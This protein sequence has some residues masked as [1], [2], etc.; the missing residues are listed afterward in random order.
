MLKP[1]QISQQTPFAFNGSNLNVLQIN[2]EPWFVAKE[3]TSILEYRNTN[4]AT[5]LLDE[6]EKGTHLMR[7]LGGDQEV[8]IINESGLYSL[9]LRSKKP[10]AKEFKRWVTHEVLPA[11][12]KHGGYL[13]P[14]KTEELIANPD[15]IIQ[16]ATSLKSERQKVNFLTNEVAQRNDIIEHQEQELRLQTP[17]VK[18]YREV[19]NATDTI[20][21]T[22]I[23]KELGMTA[24][25][26]NRILHKEYKIIFKQ[27]DTWVPYATFQKTG[28]TKT[29]TYTYTGADGSI[30][31]SVQL[32]W[33]QSGREFLHQLFKRE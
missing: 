14:E 16:L 3:I 21:A 28:Y 1:S 4:D 13:T 31:T 24:A 27:G 5:R 22:I 6:D 23:A 18:Y 12:R 15:L 19:L 17:A 7:T 33:T 2:D 9:I 29:K 25:Q 10:E 30:K 8:S 32:V 11:I 20:S 26:M